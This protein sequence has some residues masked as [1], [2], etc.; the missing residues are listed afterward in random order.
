MRPSSPVTVELLLEEPSAEVALRILMPK[1]VPGVQVNP[2][3]FPGKAALLKKLPQRLRG[4]ATWAPV[5]GHKVVIL[6]D[7]D[8]DDCKELKHRLD[9][10]AESSGLAV[11][12]RGRVGTVLNRV[13][14]EEL[15]AWFFGE[16]DALRAAYPR[17]PASIG[18]QAAYRDPDAIRGGTWEAL[19][20]V[21]QAHGCHRERLAKLTAAEE[22]AVHM[23]VDKNR[24]R[25]FQVFRDGLRRLVS[26]DT[27][28]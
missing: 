11:A 28:A 23:D 15:E 19:E 4:Y 16:V 3:S 25:S 8:D 12:S 24:S 20:R 26:G 10:I 17:L 6:V 2:V 7:R 21:L 27:D 9:D 14:I 5:A 22:I 13:V 18:Q 1:I